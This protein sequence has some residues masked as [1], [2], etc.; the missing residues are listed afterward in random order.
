MDEFSG[1]NEYRSVATVAIGIYNPRQVGLSAGKDQNYH[2]YYYQ[3]DDS[4]K[5]L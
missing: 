2:G 4:K 3:R 1:F 5:H